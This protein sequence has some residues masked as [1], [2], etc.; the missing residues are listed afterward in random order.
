MI[1]T[2]GW[3][4]ALA[5]LLGLFAPAP[6]AD[7]PRRAAADDILK[8]LR[9]QHPRLYVL[10]EDLPAI[11]RAAADDPLVRDWYERLQKE[12]RKML[13]EPP[14]E[15]RLIGRRLLDQSRAALRRIST[16][17]ALYRLDGDR[18]KAERARREMLTA[19]AFPDWNPSHFLD[20]AEMTNALAVGYDW[21]FDFLSE[22]DRAAVRAAIVE[23]GLKPGLRVY[24]KGGGWPEAHHNW[25]QVCNGGLAAG[26]LAVADEEPALAAEVLARGRESIVRAMR[27]F[28]P[29]GGWEEG[30]G[31]W[32]YATHY[33]VFY[34]AALRSALGTDFGLTRRPGFADTGNFRIHSVG[35]LGLTFNFADAGAG[36]GTAPQMLWLARAFDRPDFARHERRLARPR[37]DVFHL[38]W[39]GE[40]PADAPPEGAPRDALFRA[41]HVAF[42]RGAWDDDRAVYV[43][44]KGGDNR[45]N[46]SH[47]DLGTF[48]LDALGQRWAL[49]LGPDDYNLPGYF[50]KQRWDYYRLGTEGHNT[51]TI[52]GANQNPNGRAPVIAYLSTPERAFA[53]ADLTAGYAPKVRSARRGIALLGRQQVL[54][55]DELEASQP[56]EVVWN[57]HTRA[58]VE[59]H[60][61]RATLTQGGARLEARLLAPPGS[62]FEVVAADAPPPQAQQRDVH[63]LVVRLPERAGDVRIVV[64][65]TPAEGG[66]PVPAVEP[67]ENWV[68]AGRLPTGPK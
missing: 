49:D 41:V 25:N 60:G 8:T 20:T 38:L 5:A 68:A 33:N 40:R 32:N 30:P 12:A 39:A 51:L 56:V 24:R 28:A 67:L 4:L 47:L 2:S 62:R 53:V 46:H 14:V 6:A 58:T 44:F 17:A 22:E 45:A 50:G 7:E 36:A 13:G 43:G 42:F 65:F 66:L 37:P 11:R 52:D 55:Q 9:P 1:R 54:V 59:A 21:L 35:P 27:S 48:V 18:R 34:L 19:A 10:D 61:D 26:A 29:D 23:K 3:L 63:N 16:L 31:Y 57:C 15:H 64:L